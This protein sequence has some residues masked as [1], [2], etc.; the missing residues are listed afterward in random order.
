M[1]KKIVAFALIAALAV[2]L[3][4]PLNAGAGTLIA[5]P[6]VGSGALAQPADFS[7]AGLT[8]TS[9]SSLAS[10]V[11]TSMVDGAADTVRLLW[12][13]EKLDR[14]LDR[15]GDRLLDKMADAIRLLWKLA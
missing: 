4:V 1:K 10:S 7:E 8:W 5:V 3:A 15:M 12:K 13:L 11:K 14:N 9:P 6:A 2:A